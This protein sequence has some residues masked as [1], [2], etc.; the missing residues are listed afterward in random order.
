[1]RYVETDLSPEAGVLGD[2]EIGLLGVGVFGKGVDGDGAFGVVVMALAGV[3]G[4]SGVRDSFE[5]R[6][7]RSFGTWS[8]FW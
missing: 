7:L 6:L 2:F 1:L 8:I 4:F 5:T 3:D